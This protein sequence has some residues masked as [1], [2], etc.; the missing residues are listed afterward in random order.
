MANFEV[1]VLGHRGL[2]AVAESGGRAE[3]QCS[4]CTLSAPAQGDEDQNESGDD[5]TGGPPRRCARI[6]RP[7]VRGPDR[8]KH[9]DAGDHG[10]CAG[11]HLSVDLLTGEP[12]PD[13]ESDDQAE[14][15]DG[16]DH[17]EGGLVQGHRLED[18]PRGLQDHARQPDRLAQDLDQPR[19]VA[20]LLSGG[21]RALLLEHRTESEGERGKHSEG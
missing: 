15:R 14:R 17:H 19:R 4:G 9:D 2:E 20:A 1:E 7:T 6:G 13:G 12:Y 5:Q 21:E 8:E 11:H 16:L 10:H 18:P 3:Q